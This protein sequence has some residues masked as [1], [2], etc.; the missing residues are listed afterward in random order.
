M[1]LFCIRQINVPYNIA[2]SARYNEYV[3]RLGVVRLHGIHLK[4][5][6]ARK[7]LEVASPTD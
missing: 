5:F 4:L 1:A 2:A 3:A 7:N 6:A